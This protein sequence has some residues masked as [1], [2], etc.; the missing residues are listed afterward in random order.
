MI[1]YFWRKR[2][3]EGDTC[4]WRDAM[5]NEAEFI[6]TSITQDENPYCTVKRTNGT[7][8]AP[9]FRIPIKDLRKF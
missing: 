1:N 3:K 2:A 5:G 7:K 8:V 4:F 6:I 9:M